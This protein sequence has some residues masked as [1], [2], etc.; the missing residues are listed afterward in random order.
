MQD[1]QVCGSRFDPLGFQVVVPELGR[2]FDR[3]ECAQTARALASPSSRI[4]AA[5]LVA[6]VEPL[7]G[8]VPPARAPTAW[9]SLAAPAAAIGLLAA[10]SAAASFLWVRALDTDTAG[11]PLARSAAPP[12]SAHESVEARVQAAPTG[13][14]RA[15]PQPPEER[16][17]ASA[18]A[19]A[20]SP[21]PSGAA[22]PSGASGQNPT[23]P[24]SGPLP[25]EPTEPTPTEPTKPDSEPK[26]ARPA[27]PASLPT[28]TATGKNHP[29]RGQ[30]HFKHGETDGVHSPGHGNAPGRGG[31]GSAPGHAGHG[32]GH[33][34]HGKGH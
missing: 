32:N 26:P 1:C 20:S 16:A 23:E 22:P 30:G 10:G 15:A 33:A 24:G 17:P 29:K 8:P 19:L 11:F 5:P 6:V 7:G 18:P 9:R 14:G 21:V 27:T 28:T 31:H 3:I 4:A 12:A 25:T 2:G 13:G 34:G